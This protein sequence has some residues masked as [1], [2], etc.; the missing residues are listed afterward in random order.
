MVGGRLRYMGIP[1]LEC[2]YSYKTEFD[3]NMDTAFCNTDDHLSRTMIRHGGKKHRVSRSQDVM[4]FQL[5]KYPRMGV[6]VIFAAKLD[7]Q[8]V[9]LKVKD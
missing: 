8:H 5:Q 4:C 2:S 9:L 7:T 1:G 6:K 3:N